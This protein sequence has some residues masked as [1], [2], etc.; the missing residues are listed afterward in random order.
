[1]NNEPQSNETRV[2]RFDSLTNIGNGKIRLEMSEDEWYRLQSF[3]NHNPL[4]VTENTGN[5]VF[6]L[7]CDNELVAVFETLESVLKHVSEINDDGTSV[8]VY[9]VAANIVEHPMWNLADDGCEY[10]VLCDGI[11]MAD[12]WIDQRVVWKD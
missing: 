8:H 2:W 3:I 9:T 10:D 11:P 4:V 12:W 6:V 5:M 7:M 1:M